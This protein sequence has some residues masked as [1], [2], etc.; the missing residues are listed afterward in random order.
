MAEVWIPRFVGG[1]ERGKVGGNTRNGGSLVSYYIPPPAVPSDVP[2]E[3]GYFHI[4]T[5]ISYAPHP[6]FPAAFP[7]PIP[8]LYPMTE[9]QD[10]TPANKKKKKKS[11]GISDSTSSFHF[12]LPN[13]HLIRQ[14][15]DSRSPYY[16]ACRRPWRDGATT[17]SAGSGVWRRG[18]PRCSLGC[19]GGR[20]A[21]LER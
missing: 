14:S 21:Q 17:R 5:V 18:C 8:V 10:K 6:I 1:R 15:V 3:L 16:S 2:C 20:G 19:P 7:K 13:L 12:I 4:D 9:S 11:R